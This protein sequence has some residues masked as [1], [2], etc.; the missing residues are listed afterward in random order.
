MTNTKRCVYKRCERCGKK[1]R[2]T[3]RYK[4]LFYCYRC[5][6]QMFYYRIK[7]YPELFD[8]IDKA[9]SKNISK[10]PI[11]LKDSKFLKAYEEIKRRWLG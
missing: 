4:K 6:E 2:A 11:E 9:I 7:N 10:K 1:T 8:E 5:Y 3:W